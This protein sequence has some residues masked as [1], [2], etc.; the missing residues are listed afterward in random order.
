MGGRAGFER[1]DVKH[2]L[3]RATEES[4]LRRAMIAYFLKGNGTRKGKIF[5]ILN[6][7]FHILMPN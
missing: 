1:D 5:F 3:L 6:I 7:Q 4:E 2:T